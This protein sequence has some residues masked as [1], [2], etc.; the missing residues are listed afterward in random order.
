MKQKYIGNIDNIEKIVISDPS[1]NEDNIGRFE[2]D[3]N[4]KDNWKV[5]L[6]LNDIEDIIK[7]END[8]IRTKGIEFLIILKKPELKE[9]TIDINSNLSNIPKGLN[10][11]KTEVYMDTACVGIGV[12]NNA[13][14][15]KATKNEW[16]PSCA[17]KTLTDGY[18]GTVLEAK[19]EE[20]TEFIQITGYLDE[21][22][23]YTRDEIKNYLEKMMEIKDLRLE[24]EYES[25]KLNKILFKEPGQRPII[26][27]IEKDL[28]AEQEIVGGLIEAVDFTDNTCLICNEE[29]KLEGLMPNLKYGRDDIIV[30]NIFVIGCTEDG[31]FRSLTEQEIEE[32]ID[33]LNEMEI[34]KNQLFEEEEI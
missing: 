2:R 24:K 33:K 23:N 28:K 1:F 10:I 9:L 11:N 27:E 18:F 19:K 26:M 7:Y 6:I 8:Y 22:T 20:K 34:N 4:N 30:G 14:K 21:D 29:G 16:Q 17:L 32:C 3:Y 25:E 13:N 31:E 12:N 5:E 15:L